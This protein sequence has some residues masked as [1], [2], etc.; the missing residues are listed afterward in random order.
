MQ[1]GVDLR[2]ALLLGVAEV[3]KENGIFI[4]E[5]ALDGDG[6]NA[7]GVL[8]EVRPRK[9]NISSAELGPGCSY[10]AI[11][12]GE[13]GTPARLGHGQAPSLRQARQIHAPLHRHR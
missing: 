10:E 3:C 12:L 2:E 7:V 4:P 8:V 6:S 5:A 1:K 13:D 11:S 9:R